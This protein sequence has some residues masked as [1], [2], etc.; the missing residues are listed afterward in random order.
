MSLPDTPPD[1]VHLQLRLQ[2]PDFALDVDLN[3]PAQG[4]TALWGPSGCG[5]TSLLRCVAGLERPRAARIQVAGAVWQD[6]TRGVFVPAWKRSVGYVFQEHSLLAHLDAGGNMRLGLRHRSQPVDP[7]LVQSVQ[8]VLGISH[9]LNRRV[10]ELSGGER[11]RIALARALVMQPR[12]LML[13]EP[14]AALDDRRK[15][16]F[17]PWLVRLR[18]AVRIPVLYVTHSADEVAKLA[19]HLVVLRD[20][21]VEA[22]GPLVDVLSGVAPGVVLGEDAGALLCGVVDATDTSWHLASVR[23]DGGMLWVRDRGLRAGQSVRV[24]VLARDVSVSLQSAADT[25][26]QNLLPCTLIAIAQAGHPSQVLLQLQCGS[27]V[28]LARITARA[29]STLALQPGIPLWAQVKSVAV[30]D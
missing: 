15:Q 6:D 22:Q 2:R 21:K 28:L 14:M 26:I 18:D 30:L 24:R 1:Q 11:Q 7:G 13:D 29:A 16:E 4:I 3:L 9:L 12:I 25:S 20:G 8:D 23:F 10:H 27:A 17:L 19:D 5:K